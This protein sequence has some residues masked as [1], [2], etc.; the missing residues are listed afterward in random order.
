MASPKKSRKKPA[1]QKKCT[2]LLVD[3]HPLFRRGLADLLNR[4]LDMIVLAQANSGAEALVAIRGALFGLVIMDIGLGNGRDGLE[5]TKALRAE[6]PDLQILFVSVRDEAL[7]A[8]RA[9]RA[10]A[11][12][13]VMKRESDESILGGIRAVIAG[14]IYVSAWM[15][16]RLIQNHIHGSSEQGPAI[17]L[18]TDRELEVFHLIGH[19]QAVREIATNLKL[20]RKTIEAHREHIKEKLDFRTSR[21][22]TYFAVQRQQGD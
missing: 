5:T 19:G 13:Y 21:E 20:S 12:G 15:Q 9:L 16:K 11:R 10:G 3:D 2:I 7:Y 14:E 6:Q 22:L 17:D 4:E 18:L 8:G 1:T